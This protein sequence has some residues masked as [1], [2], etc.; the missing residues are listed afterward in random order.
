MTG[1]SWRVLTVFALA[2]V[3]AMPAS[4][5]PAA[6][7]AG[8]GT[9]TGTVKS[10]TTGGPIRSVR[11]MLNGT[12]TVVATAVAGTPGAV[13]GTEQIYRSTGIVNGTATPQVP[14]A[15]IKTTSTDGSGRFSFTGL[16]A[17]RY[18]LDAAND[19]F[20]PASFG[21]RKPGR[22]GMPIELAEGQRLELTV[23]MTRGSAI[24]GSVVD[25]LGDPLV[26]A[27]VQALR[28]IINQNGVKRLRVVGQAE[29]DD[30]GVYRLFGL[31]PGDYHVSAM[32]GSSDAEP[33]RGSIGESPGFEVGF[34]ADPGG[35]RD[36]VPRMA[37]PPDPTGT[38]ED[39]APTYYPM[40]ATGAGSLPVTVD[41]L[42]ERSGVDIR[43]L[44]IHNGTIRGTVVGM[45]PS[46]PVQVLLHNPDGS[47]PPTSLTAMVGQSGEFTLKNVA[48][49]EYVVYAQTLPSSLPQTPAAINGS[50]PVVINGSVATSVAVPTVRTA[51]FD[52]LHGRT[53]VT[54]DGSI[55]PPISIALQPGRSISG[56]VTFD[57]TQ[58][59]GASAARAV[60][61]I[62][63]Q[64][65]PQAGGWP[66]FN[67]SPTVRVDA[68]GNFVLPGIRPGRFFL[69]ASG[70][71]TVRSVMWNG[72]DTLDFPLE[73]GTDQDVANVVITLTD[74]L[75]E[76]SGAVTDS[77]GKPGYDFTVIAMP[78]DSRFWIPG[79][80]RVAI[81]RTD[82]DGRYMFRGLPPGDYRLATL[83]DFDPA[84]QYDFAQLQ[85][86]AGSGVSMTIIG[87]GRHVMNLKGTR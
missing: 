56:H 19:A 59:A 86:L 44:P 21:Q 79:S 72:L 57:F 76:L 5:Q 48:P 64:P 46:L 12:A 34:T 40:S 30:R 51:A 7:T 55:T 87:T 65:A 4:A 50:V 14:K 36:A 29:T 8:T 35:A 84:T 15:V 6:A 13:G 83:V 3:A 1:W 74:K 61:T 33:M 39:L 25:E 20:L 58:T 78:V 81:S 42:A 32:P 38:E 67:T 22:P 16:P 18:L 11:V 52:R 82:A 28:Y 66:A 24:T 17:G 47:E 69:R 80:R 2:A 63:I 41:G 75:S 31:E 49:G 71:G 45:P 85:L 54:V 23:S 37:A 26:H 77:T 70:P 60:T 43:V 62:S 73:V 53:A 27:R 10:L 9:I 68:D